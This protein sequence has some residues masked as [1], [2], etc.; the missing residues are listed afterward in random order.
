MSFEARVVSLT[1]VSIFIV[2]VNNFQGGRCSSD[3]PFI[4]MSAN[5]V[6][7][8]GWYCCFAQ[9]KPRS[10]VVSVVGINTCLD[11]RPYAFAVDTVSPEV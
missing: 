6:F 5:L 10:T 4:V 8:I 2:E 1:C 11:R 3:L 7:L 9:H